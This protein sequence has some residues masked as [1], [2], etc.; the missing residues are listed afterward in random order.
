MNI[1]LIIST[2]IDLSK[3][4][5]E[6]NEV[7]VACVI[8]ENN[9]IVSKAYN[10]KNT[11]KNPLLHAEVIAITKLCKK[12]NDWRLN[13]CEM[14]VTLKPCKMCYEIIKAARIKKCYYFLDTQGEEINPD[15][16]LINLADGSEK[17]KELIQ[18]FFASKR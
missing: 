14:Y 17:F 15:T 5:I 4:A 7:P 3:K 10:L 2:L 16:E 11:K 9:E 8:V 18:S 6:K 13:N 1:D 12:K